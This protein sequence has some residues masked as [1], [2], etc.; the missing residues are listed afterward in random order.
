MLLS[1]FGVITAIKTCGK[2]ANMSLYPIV[3]EKRKTMDGM[4]VLQKEF[5]ESMTRF[6]LF[7]SNAGTLLL[8]FTHGHAAN[9][10]KCA[11]F[12]VMMLQCMHSMY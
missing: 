5:G 12:C 1:F 3:A 8:L 6:V 4:P 2:H 9:S 11:L 10:R 7:C